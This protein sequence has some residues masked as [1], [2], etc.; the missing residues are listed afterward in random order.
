MIEFRKLEIE[1]IR[2]GDDEGKLKGTLEVDG[3][4]ARIEV[5]LTDAAAKKILQCAAA[6]IA[7]AASEQAQAFRDEFL[8]AVNEVKHE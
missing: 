8:G 1:K 4:T 6:D 5:K 3:R 2:Y 7:A